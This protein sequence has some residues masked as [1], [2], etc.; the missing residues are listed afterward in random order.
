MFFN[1]KEA[2]KSRLSK[3]PRVSYSVASEI[4]RKVNI[5]LSSIA[6]GVLITAAYVFLSEVHLQREAYF[7]KST[8]EF[9]QIDYS[10]KVK[11]KIKQRWHE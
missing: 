3:Q 9:R 5:V 11:L 6:L 1:K 8:G 7:V 4:L 10:E 2:I